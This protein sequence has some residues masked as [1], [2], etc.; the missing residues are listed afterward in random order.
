MLDSEVS[1]PPAGQLYLL[2]WDQTT[3]ASDLKYVQG[4]ETVV[5]FDADHQYPNG[6]YETAVILTDPA[7]DFYDAPLPGGGTKSVLR[8][9]LNKSLSNIYTPSPLT[10]ASGKCAAVGV[11]SNCDCE[12]NQINSSNSCFY[13]ADMREIQ[14]TF[15]P[16]FDS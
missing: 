8:V 4:G 14:R 9:Y 5:V 15:N 16:D 10:F 3:P 13:D 6:S 1:S 11:I 7:P 2:R 12:A